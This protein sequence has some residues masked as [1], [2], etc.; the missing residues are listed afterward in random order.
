MITT[1][2]KGFVT[3]IFLLV[4][5]VLSA[6]G[7]GANDTVALP[8]YYETG[9]IASTGGELVWVFASHPPTLDPNRATDTTSRNVMRTM[10]EPLLY[11]GE[12]NVLSPLLASSYSQIDDL[13]WEFTLQQGVTFHDGHPFNADVVQINFDRFLDPENAFT[14][15]DFLD[16]IEDVVVIDD[17]TVHF[18]LSFPFA[19][20]P[21]Q[22]TNYAALMISPNAI[23]EELDGG[24]TVNENP[25]GTGPF[26]LE[27]VSHGDSVRV[28]RFDDHWRGQAYL[29]S[30]LF[31]V[32]PEPATRLALIETGEA[33]GTEAMLSDVPILNTMPHIRQ[34]T[35][36]TTTL[37]YIGFNLDT[38][39][40]DDVR[41]RQAITMAI[42]H[43]DILYGIAEGQ[44]VRAV[45][46]IAPTVAHS[47]YAV[48]DPLPFDPVRAREL[49]V[50]AG[51]EDGFEINIWYNDGNSVRGLIAQLVQSNLADIGITVHVSSI[52]WGAYLEA[53][54]AGEHDMFVLGWTGGTGDPDIQVQP[55]FHTDVI[56]G[57]NRFWYSNTEIDNLIEQGRTETDFAARAE[58]YRQI[59]E[60]LIYDA[61]AIFLF[62]P[63][64]PVITNGVYGLVIDFAVTPDFFRVQLAE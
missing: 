3:A 8:H 44:G 64:Q 61:P 51:H 34:H 58:I 31:R 38:P 21:A 47:P 2:T 63:F 12:G 27:S 1:R 42:N 53:T 36:I 37:N 19:P 5:F 32:I 62:H 43:D 20:F 35:I 59:T 26:M 15:A 40:M 29:D 39:P 45:G 60:I 13:T 48:L 30:I 4:P 28:V 50:E 9:A 57:G 52:E 10:M 22:I 18:I 56:G 55:L 25:V 23:Q 41:V 14:R 33:H 54:S 7:V 6:C 46:P 24:R 16:M 11:F 49:L 17:Y